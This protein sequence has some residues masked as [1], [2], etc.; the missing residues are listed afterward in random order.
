[1]DP[2]EIAEMAIGRWLMVMLLLAMPAASNSSV[3][4]Y[5]RAGYAIKS[6][7]FSVKANGRPVDVVH[8][9]DYHYAHF[10][11]DGTVQM[12]VT[13]SETIHTFDVA[14]H[15][16]KIGGT[17][18]GRELSFVLPTARLTP[19]YLVIQINKLEK[20]VIL[21][22]PLEKKV[23]SPTG[24]K[25]FS[26]R[27]PPYNA[28]PTGKIDAT[29][30]LQKAIDDAGSACGGVV[31]VPAGA[32][33]VTKT[34]VLTRDNVELYLEGGA[35]IK[36]SEDRSDYAGTDHTKPVIQVKG[37]S[38]VSIRG[39]GTVD[40][41]GFSLFNKVFNEQTQK[42]EERRAAVR[43]DKCADCTVEGI[44]VK[45]GTSW[46]LAAYTCE[47]VLIRNL[48]VLNFKD[49]NK[50]KIQ[51]D[52]IDMCSTRHARVDKCFV[53]TVDDALCAKAMDE[54]HPMYG[55][56]FTNNVL[57]T[58]CAG[59]KSGM[60][61]RSE[62]RDIWFVDNDIIQCRRGLVVEATTGNALMHDIHYLDARIERQVPIGEWA[63][64]NMDF[65]AETASFRDIEMS[66]IT[67]EELH[68]SQFAV[69]KPCTIDNISLNQIYAGKT[70]V[71]NVALFRKTLDGE[72]RDIKFNSES[73][74]RQEAESIIARLPGGKSK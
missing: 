17:K 50:Y 30:I 16:L 7:A 8:F 5:P 42:Y 27:K 34:L 2:E 14:P 70:H 20:L 39:R 3:V 53:M 56:A 24:S 61:A 47:R 51:N 35:V 37:A 45:D 32:Y 41:G 54:N 55:V 23:P 19:T 67:F 9:T 29:A 21:A 46:T 4:T 49:A 18:N 64:K 52:G 38:G 65:V 22:D 25:V 11:F 60:Q 48:K 62:M 59:H 57:F 44:V 36:A 43:F 26:I 68:K 13:A 72:L 73:T 12:V 6:D 69:K 40:A 28:D 71:G 63:P 10:S 66:R 31:Y 33:K 1:V 15:S 58:S 74:T